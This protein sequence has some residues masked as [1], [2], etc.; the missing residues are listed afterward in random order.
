MRTAEY[1]YVVVSRY[2][3][4]R[5]PQPEKMIYPGQDVTAN[6]YLYSILVHSER[7]IHA[8]QKAISHFI[9]LCLQLN[10]QQSLHA[11]LE[12]AYRYNS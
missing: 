3:K 8:Y 12:C 1:K 5:Q 9:T 2:I 6:I 7:A 11:S 4:R 10:H